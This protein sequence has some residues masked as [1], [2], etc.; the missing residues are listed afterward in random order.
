V[1]YY[2]DSLSNSN[3]TPKPTTSAK[4]EVVISEEKVPISMLRGA[5][6]SGPRISHKMISEKEENKKGK[7]IKNKR[8]ARQRAKEQTRKK[9]N[10]QIEYGGMTKFQAKAMT[11]VKQNLKKDPVKYNKSA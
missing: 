5:P 1:N 11:K 4:N 3:F 2:L 8:I 9:V 10:K 6:D 7:R